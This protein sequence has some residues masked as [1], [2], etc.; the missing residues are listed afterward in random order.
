MCIRD[1]YRLVIEA[2][3]QS[4]R[5]CL[6]SDSGALVTSDSFWITPPNPAFPK[7]ELAAADGAV[8]LTIA[9]ADIRFSWRY[10]PRERLDALASGKVIAGKRVKLVSDLRS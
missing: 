6:R 5:M 10:V 3:R 2:P 9:C 8:V 4:L 1:R 7:P